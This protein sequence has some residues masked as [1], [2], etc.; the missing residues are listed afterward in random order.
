VAAEV[1]RIPADGRRVLLHDQGD[2]AVGEA[3]GTKFYNARIGSRR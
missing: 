2:G 1:S 3:L